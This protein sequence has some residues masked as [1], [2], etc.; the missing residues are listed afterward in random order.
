MHMCMSIFVLC[1]FA[2][3][4]YIYSSMGAFHKEI[5]KII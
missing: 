4:T 1:T 3:Y 5:E 2:I